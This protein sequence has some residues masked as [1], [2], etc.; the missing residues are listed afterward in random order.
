MRGDSQPSERAGWERAC[1]ARARAGDAEAF[2]ELYRAFAPALYRNLLLPKLGSAEAAED[3]LSE[4][5]REL[6]E[7]IAQIHADGRSLWPWLCRVAANKAYDMHRKR[8]RAR[9]ALISFEG[10]LAPFQ[11]GDDPADALE[12]R[13]RSAELRG[14]IGRALA[15]LNPRYRQAIELRFLEDRG[16]DQC[17]SMMQLKLGTFDVLLLRALRAF[18]REW[19]AQ[20]APAKRE[21]G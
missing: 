8:A 10:L 16:R 15:A 7:H 4:S 11:A 6:M 1:V 21:I 20:L 5:F 3:A 17:A 14:A 9:R 18:R 19:Q 13:D 2:A 12:A